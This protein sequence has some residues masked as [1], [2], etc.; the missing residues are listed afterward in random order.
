MSLWKPKVIVET[1]V[2]FTSGILKAIKMVVGTILGLLA[3][4]VVL[5][6]AILIVML[7]SVL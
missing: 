1:K 3:A 4:M 6:F 7:I 5:Q 2:S